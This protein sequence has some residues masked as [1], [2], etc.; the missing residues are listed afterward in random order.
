M[1]QKE[2]LE[3][4]QRILERMGKRNITEH[5]DLTKESILDSIETIDFIVGMQKRFG[6]KISER[7]FFSKGLSKVSDL[8]AFLN[9]TDREADLEK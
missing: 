1:V 7:D 4:V 9:S 5:T 6:V 2:T 3:K 8:V